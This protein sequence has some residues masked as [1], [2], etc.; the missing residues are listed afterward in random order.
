MKHHQ[1]SHVMESMN[2]ALYT[3]VSTCLRGT[4]IIIVEL[5]CLE[6]VSLTNQK[7]RKWSPWLMDRVTQDQLVTSNFGGIGITSPSPLT[8]LVYHYSSNH[9]GVRLNLLDLLGFKLF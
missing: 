6:A 4:S 8:F 9:I 7:A 1:T 5:D 3:V 2:T